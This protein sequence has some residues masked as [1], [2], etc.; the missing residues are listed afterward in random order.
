MTPV[1]HF[2]LLREPHGLAVHD[3]GGAVE[4]L[5]SRLRSNPDERRQSEFLDL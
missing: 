2:S 4:A 5:R 1:R 3:D